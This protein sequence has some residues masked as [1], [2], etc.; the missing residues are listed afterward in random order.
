MSLS[1]WYAVPHVLHKKKKTS[2]VQFVYSEV[3]CYSWKLILSYIDRYTDIYITDN[4]VLMIV[5]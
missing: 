4:R 1:I 3:K 2:K 5:T